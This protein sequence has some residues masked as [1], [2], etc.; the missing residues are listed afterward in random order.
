MSDEDEREAEALQLEYNNAKERLDQQLN[1]LVQFGDQ[2][3]KMLRI[4]LV[5]IG[6]LLTA[7]TGLGQRLI[8]SQYNLSQCA[9]F[10]GE[11][12]FTVEFVA[13]LKSSAGYTF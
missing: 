2:G 3:M 7:S 8:G 11:S 1:A 13:L 5:F 6:L 12:C 4:E 10:R 9:V